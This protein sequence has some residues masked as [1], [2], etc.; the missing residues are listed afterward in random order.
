VIRLET[1]IDHPKLALLKSGGSTCDSPATELRFACSL[2]HVKNIFKKNIRLSPSLP[3]YCLIFFKKNHFLFL[4]NGVR[5]DLH[6]D[7]L[8]NDFQ[9]VRDRCS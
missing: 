8:R 4:K 3:R 9:S 6:F 5:K 2:I 7:F 1:G